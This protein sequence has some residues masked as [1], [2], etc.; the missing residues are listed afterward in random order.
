M[1]L[2]SVLR[3]LEGPQ[4]LGRGK[5]FWSG[6]L[7]ILAVAIAYPQF[8]DGFDVGNNIYF[9]ISKRFT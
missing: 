3:L 9:F 5:P 7:L 1:S 8:A 6:F 2:K 4:T